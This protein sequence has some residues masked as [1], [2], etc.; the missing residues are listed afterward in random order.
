[1]LIS[2]LLPDLSKKHNSGQTQRAEPTEPGDCSAHPRCP[3]L[4]A[5]S[6][7][8]ARKSEGHFPGGHSGG[9]GSEARVNMGPPFG[10]CGIGAMDFHV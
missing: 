9:G 1:M 7:C 4:R 3:S 6:V 8:P 2:Q 5:L 10:N